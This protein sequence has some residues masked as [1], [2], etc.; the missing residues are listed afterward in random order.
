MLFLKFKIKNAVFT[1][2]NTTIYKHRPALV[3][4][5]INY[6]LLLNVI[7]LGDMIAHML[8]FDIT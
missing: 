7:L 2:F 6:Y 4:M 1:F 5:Y 3:Y 8:H